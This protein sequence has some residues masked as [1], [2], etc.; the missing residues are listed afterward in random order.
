MGWGWVTRDLVMHPLNYQQHIALADII[1][2]WEIIRP[3][4]FLQRQGTSSGTLPTNPSPFENLLVGKEL[5]QKTNR[6]NNG[7]SYSLLPYPQNPVSGTLLN[8]VCP[9]G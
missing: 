4:S 1:G 7:C 5:P 9:G 6:M 8:L 3:F 2:S